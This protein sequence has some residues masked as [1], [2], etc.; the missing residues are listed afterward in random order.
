MMENSVSLPRR[1]SQ[2]HLVYAV[3]RWQVEIR[4][5]GKLKAALST[6]TRKGKST[7]KPTAATKPPTEREGGKIIV[8]HEYFRL[9]LTAPKSLRNQLVIELPTL[10]GFRTTEIS[11]LQAE[12][13]DVP[14]GDIQV[15]DSKKNTIFTLP[16]DPTV[17]EHY[18]QYV[19]ETGIYQG[20]L[21]QGRKRTG[22]GLSVTHIERIW[23]DQCEA[24]G[25][26]TMSPRMGRAYFA[27]VE[28]FVLGKPL[29]YVKF[30]LRHD[31]LQSTEHYLYNRI[32]SYDDMK[33]LF[34]RGKKSR[35]FMNQNLEMTNP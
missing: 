24:C 23:T 9:L 11:T 27:V 7:I 5:N 3:I 15:L 31:S 25:V 34:Y 35:L 10:Q 26:P 2:S 18:I 22:K 28:H 30:M 6:R 4:I 19:H 14:N 33:A 12:W 20:A 8:Y 29:G 17:A 13:V 1:I 32:V 21:L 16:L